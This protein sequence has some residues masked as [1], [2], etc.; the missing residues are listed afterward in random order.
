MEGRHPGMTET[1]QDVPQ[2]KSSR[3]ERLAGALDSWQKVVLALTALLVAVGGLVTAV[4]KVVQSVHSQTPQSIVGPSRSPVPGQSS[5]N[6]GQPSASPSSLATPAQLG[7]S[8]T[9]F[10]Q[11]EGNLNY[12]TASG[13][14]PAFEYFASFNELLASGGANLAVLDPPAPAA[15]AAYA[16]CRNDSAYTDMIELNSL[17]PGSTVCVF[18][19]NQQ[20]LWVSFLPVDPNSQSSA[21]HISVLDWQIPG[22]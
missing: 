20:I 11:D 21:L 6:S 17:K 22:G 16:A 3:Q 5:P 8:Q 15:G 14:Q 18:T 10:I 2:R 4:V 1:G 13:M 7:P 12:S 9:L 19:P